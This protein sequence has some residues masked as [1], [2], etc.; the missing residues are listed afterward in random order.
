M[1]FAFYFI[2]SYFLKDLFIHFREGKRVVGGGAEGDGR[3][4]P[5]QTLHT[6][7]GACCR[8]DPRTLGSRP[9][10]KPRVRH[11]ADCASQVPLAF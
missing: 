11:L 9:E 8:A 4:N 10:L 6:E 7:R 1:S 2:F 5:K 3:E